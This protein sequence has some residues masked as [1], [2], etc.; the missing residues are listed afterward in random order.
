MYD[1]I[2]NYFS[3]QM[4]SSMKFQTK[5]KEV[6][7]NIQKSFKASAGILMLVAVCSKPI[8]LSLFHSS[9]LKISSI[10]FPS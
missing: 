9:E 5:F 1:H 3:W 8:T 2:S 10:K 6:P 7:T 4:K